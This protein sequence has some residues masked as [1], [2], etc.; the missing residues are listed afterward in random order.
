MTY[1]RL[2]RK[3]RKSIEQA[4]KSGESMN[5]IAKSL[6]RASSTIARE[7]RRNRTQTQARS[8]FNKKYADNNCLHAATCFKHHLCDDCNGTIDAC[9][10]CMRCNAVC[11]D[12]KPVF[13]PRRDQRP[14]CCNGCPK[15]RQCH[16]VKYDYRWKAADD[17]AEKKLHESRA[18]L[19][20]TD[21]ELEQLNQIVTPRLKNGLSVHRVYVDNIDQMP[22]SEKTL[23]AYLEAGLFEADLFDLPRKLQR[24]PYRR[25]PELRVDKRCHVNRCYEDFLT[26]KAEN[27]GIPVVQMDTVEGAK[28][29]RKVLLTL[30]WVQSGFLMA[31]LLERQTSAEV[32]RVFKDLQEKLGARRFMQL[33]PV[34]LTDRGS[35]FTNPRAIEFMGEQ[36]VTRLFYCD[37]R[38]PQ[39]KAEIEN[40]HAILRRKFPKGRSLDPYRQEDV[41]EA[42]SHTNSYKRA[43]KQERAPLELFLF[44]YGERIL[45]VFPLKR[46]PDEQVNLLEQRATDIE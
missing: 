1:I 42:L 14:G 11:D 10:Q 16:L 36:E 5:R 25:R 44:T 4:L 30:K 43:S 31:F 32:T 21:D 12:F 7:I 35:E 45:E 17:Y 46:I 37:P 23:Y 8:A 22:V 26:Y 18:G 29:S 6:G 33:F 20:L 28:G 38:Q 39:Q 9:R 3:E 40:E 19:S 15:R 24:K 41:L 34:I 27:P 13:C 2:T